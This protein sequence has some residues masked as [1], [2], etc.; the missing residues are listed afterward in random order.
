VLSSH[1]L[2][3][4]DQFPLNPHR[5]IVFF[6]MA[7]FCL[8]IFAPT[9]HACDPFGCM[10]TGH[11]QDTLVLGEVVATSGTTTD[12]KI[13]SV[14]PQNHISSLK[15]GDRISVLGLAATMNGIYTDPP[16][17]TAGN[18]Y[19]MSLNQ[20]DHAYSSAWGIYQVRGSH[21][22]NVQFLRTSS[23]SIDAAM[24]IFINSGGIE[25]DFYTMGEE[26]FWRPSDGRPERQIYPA[27]NQNNDIVFANIPQHKRQLVLPFLALAFALIAIG[28]VTYR[29]KSLSH[30]AS[31]LS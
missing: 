2:H 12:I 16:H 30:R 6:F 28:L 19:V 31:P 13:I 11:H 21:Y 8:L 27:I 3:L 18:T 15:V 5:Q 20:K 26:V 1:E 7:A 23:P 4:L 24:R 25:D 22:S 17:I 29:R 14:F 9:V 10:M